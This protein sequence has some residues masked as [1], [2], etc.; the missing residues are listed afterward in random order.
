MAHTR[1][2]NGATM[3]AR[4]RHSPINKR[5]I[6]VAIGLAIVLLAL[7]GWAAQALGVGR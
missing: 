2:V 1:L 7:G 5:L 6:L 3:G 4:G